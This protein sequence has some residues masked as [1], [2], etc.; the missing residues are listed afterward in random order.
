VT[1]TDQTSGR[2][3][4]K[5]ASQQPSLDGPLAKLRRAHTHLEQLYGELNAYTAEERHRVAIEMS[6]EGAERLYTMRV[7]VLE[8]L[9]NPGWGLLVGDFAHNLRGSLDHLVWQLVLLNGRQPSKA[10]QF[11]IAKDRDRYWVGTKEKQSVRER[12]LAG[13]AEAHRQRID[14]VQPFCA[15]VV[16]GLYPDFHVLEVLARLSNTDKH[17]LITSALVNIGEID[18][19]M[20]DISTADGSGMAVFEIYQHALFEDRT[21]IAKVR[22][23][24]VT[25]GLGVKMK[26]ELPLE[27]GFGYPKGI[28]S[29]GLGM[30]YEFVRDLVKDF[31][32]EFERRQSGASSVQ[33]SSHTSTNR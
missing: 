6:D 3:P 11:P 33:G 27:I 7:E 23:R 10:N 24:G 21:E 2:E 5:D 14:A 19:Q 15:P 18:E 31:H 9:D 8:P 17:Q 30:L 13:V 26:V 25:P 22:M 29:D 28:R 32:L 4:R 16:D 20:F 12:T 1:G